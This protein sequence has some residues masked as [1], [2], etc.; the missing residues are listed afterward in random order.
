MRRLLAGVL[1]GLLAAC[2]GDPE[3]AAAPAA[4]RVVSGAVMKG[5]VENAT[6]EFYTLDVAGNAVALVTTVTTDANGQFSA[7]LP[8][9]GAHL[10]ARTLGGSY[11]DESD[12]APAASRRRI[13]LPASPTVGL[14]AVLPPNATSFAITPYSNALLIKARLQ[15]GG[16]NFFNVFDAVRAQATTAFGFDPITTVPANPV[17]PSAAAT[18]A[19]RQYALLL[20]AASQAINSLAV[21]SGRLPDFTDV[22]AFIDDLGLDG[23]FDAITLEEHLRRFRNNNFQLY[24]GV[25]LP[26]L[27]EALLSQPATVPNARPVA[28]ADAITVSEGGT[29][30]VLASANTSVLDNDTDAEGSTLTAAVGATTANGTLVLNSDG[31]FSYT[32]NGGETASDSFTYTASDGTIAS[33][34]AT[35]SITVSAVN[36]A[37]VAADD[38]GYT[39]TVGGTITRAAGAG[40]VRDNDTD[41]DD[42][43]A[44]LTVSPISGP[45]FATSFTLSADGGFTYEHDGSANLVDTFTYEVCDVALPPLCDQAV[46]T[47]TVSSAAANQVVLPYLDSAGD[48]KLFDPAD[49]A[50]PVLIE[51]GL[52]TST[53][54]W[55]TLMKASV[56]AGVASNIAPARLVYIS[57]DGTV[58][59]VNLEPGQSRSPVQISNISDACKINGVAEDFATPDA[60]IVRIDTAGTDGTC[61]DGGGDD[62]TTAAAW[63]VPLSTSGSSPGVQVGFGHCCGITAIGTPSG[64]LTGVLSAEDDGT[65]GTFF[66]RRRN[67]GTLATPAASFNLEIAGTGQVYGSLQRGMGDTHI[68]VR[69]VRDAI[70]TTYKILR[71]NV[72][73]NTLTAVYDY[74]ISDGSL[75]DENFDHAF[76]DNTSVY[77]AE[78]DG[79][80]ILSIPH[81]ATTTTEFSI[82]FTA[83]GGTKINGFEPAGNR[84]AIEASSA[85]GTQGGVYSIVNTGGGLVQLA[86]N[87]SVPSTSRLSGANGALVLIDT[88]AGTASPAYTATAITADGVTSTPISDAQWA[89]ETFQPSCDFNLGCEE[90]VAASALYV[91][92]QASTTNAELELADTTTGAPT[93]TYVGTILNVFEGPAAA[94]IGFGNYGQVTVF[95]SIEQSDLFLADSD[96]A[97][98]AP[99]GTALVAVANAAGGG[100]NYW[101]SFDGEIGGGG[102]GADSD[103]DGLTDAQE[104]ALGTDPNNPDTDADGLTDGDEVNIYGT[105]PTLLDTDADG[106]DDGV[107]LGFTDPVNPDT[108]ADGVGDGVENLAGTDPVATTNTVIYANAACGAGCDGT[109]WATG[110]SSQIDVETAIGA[111]DPANMMFVLYAPGTYASLA[112]T[113]E[114]RTN[115]TLVG[116]LGDGIWAP[117][118][119]PTTAF[120]GQGAG[121][122]LRV[123]DVVPFYVVGFDLTGGNMAMGG[124]LLLDVSTTPVEAYVIKSRI[125]GNT[126]EQGGGVAMFANAGTSDDY[127]R[128]EESEVFNNTA[129]SSVSAEGGGIY[130]SDGSLTLD[131]V[132]LYNNI[133]DNPSTGQA[134]GGGL[135]VEAAGIGIV[136]DESFVSG[137]AANCTGSVTG[138]A[139]GGIYLAGSAQVLFDLTRTKFLNNSTSGGVSPDSGGAGLYAQGDSRLAISG[140]L[141][142][143]NRANNGPGGGINAMEPTE[144]DT[145]DSLFLSNASLRP[146]GGLH[147]HS[148][149]NVSDTFNNLFVGNVS[150]DTVTDGGAVEIEN[151]LL[152]PS[153]TFTSNTVVWNQTPN[154]ATDAGGGVSF[155]N[156]ADFYNNIVWFNQNSSPT[157]TDTGDNMR[158][159]GSLG[160]LGNNV[161]DPGMPG[162]ITSDPLFVGGLYL[163]PDAPSP[164]IDAGDNSRAGQLL[165]GDYWT[166]PAGTPDSAPVD[167]GYHYTVSAATLDFVNSP[168]PLVCPSSAT[169]DIDVVPHFTGGSGQTVQPGH[170]VAVKFTAG[171]APSSVTALTTLQPQG[172][173]SV[174]AR[175]MGDGRYRFTVS[176]GTAGS[177]T[178]TVYVDDFPSQ[179]IPVQFTDGC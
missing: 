81:T 76:F 132:Q 155:S 25:E 7:A 152:G 178:L 29:A 32:H 103:F 13:A 77:F 34:A 82:L 174:L 90:S 41:P 27:N 40:G 138:C 64:A 12:P 59:K 151:P 80:E 119:P 44:N 165:N 147:I 28:N 1:C 51:S 42:L 20:G 36:D 160:A 9:T 10:L 61:S 159:D 143:D 126:A 116:S 104:I 154:T 84:L 86:A 108:D 167:M 122:A 142:A 172:T 92:R 127:L 57:S 105:D 107:E 35:V 23:A 22:Q 168:N 140:V 85:D 139:G 60:S 49:P 96:Q 158:W 125:Y 65:G 14:E 73:T 161:Q 4:P 89:G 109:S 16:I 173:G 54:T 148:G 79:S 179:P 124:G 115:V 112:L 134:R 50:N 163:D 15:A 21:S 121:P 94:V 74:G 75:F 48:L 136:I 56:T 62:F 63:L 131:K 19:S 53:F 166:N 164:S 99:P 162:S 175:D 71:F 67:V 135:Y 133:A 93:G 129:T 66:L 55:R 83:P 68:Y 47:L 171:T 98:A 24:Q 39:G 177:T 78:F 69:A 5:A 70:D 33:L 110:F 3:P 87:N 106:V 118:Y 150:T 58:K 137:N 169:R 30:T 101:L 120:D 37:P 156:Q 91:R 102:G 111:G 26:V 144:I 149:A 2:G 113:D 117:S 52:S 45:S 31:T 141:F 43:T 100:D 170:V 88:I 123:A 97:A 114:P 153:P 8:S 146:G 176:G 130:M 11:L 17:A 128:I 145:S 38:P 157:T 95:A 72:A 18:L 46:A 6:V